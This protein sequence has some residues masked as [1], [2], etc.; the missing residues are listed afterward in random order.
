M[1]QPSPTRINK[2]LWKRLP[3]VVRAVVAGF[4]VMM[5]GVQ[6]WGLLLMMTSP[7]IA[8]AVM[9]VLLVLYWFFFSG[10]V[11]SRATMAVRRE[12]FRETCLAPATWKWSLGAAALFVIAMEASIFTLFRLI[13]F[14]AQQFAMPAL[15]DGTPA[16]GLWV[17]LIVASLVAGICEETAF[18]G[19]L[20]RPLEARY[21][22]AVA[23]AVGTVAFVA[24]HLN[25][26]WVVTLL[27][28]LVLAGV[29]LGVLAYAARSL[30]PGMIGH[31]VMDVFNFSY[32]WWSLIGHYDRRPIF[33][34][35][36]D[37]DFAFWAGTLAV[38]LT[39]FAMFVRKLL[40]LRQNEAAVYG[41]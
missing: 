7:L 6:S 5:V 2:S 8:V 25:Q 15:L 23:I 32:W 34:S 35:G 31:T 37:L 17:G 41:S 22:P 29:L 19:Y 10:R 27:G 24:A 11:F 20:Q 12:N 21:G 26:A 18:R 38:S 36:I 33:E 1:S 39:L 13:P 30:V 28:P 9:P 3:L 40:A 16:P 4:L 14:R